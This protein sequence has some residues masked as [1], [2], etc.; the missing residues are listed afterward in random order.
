MEVIIYWA[1]WS[2]KK[3]IFSSFIVR[4]KLYIL[5]VVKYVHYCS[6]EQSHQLQ[7]FG[8]RAF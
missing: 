4:K 5:Q 6:C 8:H 7:I 2:E 1:K 3:S